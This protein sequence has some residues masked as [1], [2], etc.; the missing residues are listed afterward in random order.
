MYIN[1]FMSHLRYWDA[2]QK[3]RQ[4]GG[5]RMKVEFLVFKRYYQGF[6]QNAT[7]MPENAR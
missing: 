4:M 1:I 6:Y 5:G 7:R 2:L 3:L